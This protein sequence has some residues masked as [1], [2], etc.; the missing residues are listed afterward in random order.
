[1]CLDAN[2]VVAGAASWSGSSAQIL[3][4]VAAGDLTLVVTDEIEGEYRA[5]A[6]RPSVVGLF[7]RRRVP[8]REYMKILDGLC[9]AAERVAPTGEAPPCRDEDD[10]KYLHCALY[11]GV[12]FIVT[13]DRDLLDQ[14]RIGGTLIVPPDELLERLRKSGETLAE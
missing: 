11:A 13:R 14:E 10:R 5:I 8:A 1:M 6:T 4:H 12:D 9:A 2:T 7:E 3:R